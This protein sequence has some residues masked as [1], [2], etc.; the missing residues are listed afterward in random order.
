MDVEQFKEM[1]REWVQSLA[2]TVDAKVIAIDGK[3]SRRSYDGDN[4]MLHMVS[5]FASEARIVLAQ[6]KLDDK[7]NEITAIPKLLNLLDVKGY[8]VTID[9]MGCQ[10]AI[11]EQIVEKGGDYIFSLKGN[12]G[13]LASDTELYCKRFL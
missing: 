7:S 8:I 9:A 6:E 3:S 13:N 10:Y 5:A 12:Q 2:K 1:F 4:S 11:A